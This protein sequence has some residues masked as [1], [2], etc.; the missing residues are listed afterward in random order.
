MYK[1]VYDVP[2][3]AIIDDE[4]GVVA[5]FKG[6]YCLF[7]SYDAAFASFKAIQEFILK[8]N[9]TATISMVQILLKDL[10][11]YTIHPIAQTFDGHPIFES[12]IRE[13]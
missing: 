5:T 9:H 1:L 8:N 10:A 3:Y 4:T 6:Q 2:A 11:P 7:N 13:E 12:T